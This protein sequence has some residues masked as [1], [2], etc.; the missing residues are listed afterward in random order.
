MTFLDGTIFE[1]NFDSDEISSTLP[2]RWSADPSLQ[3]CVV[4]AKRGR[5][6][7]FYHNLVHEGTAP[8]PGHV[9]YIIRSDLMYER[10]DPICARPQD[11]A[12]YELYREAVEIAGVAGRE[13]EALP[14]F[15]WAFAMSRPLA[16]LYGM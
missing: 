4:A 8:A 14:L 7:V 16:D 6:L 13:A 2:F 5:C 11:V 12:A 1:G 3:R 10:R 9:K 15:R